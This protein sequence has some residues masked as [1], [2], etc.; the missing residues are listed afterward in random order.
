MAYE[1]ERDRDERKWFEEAGPPFTPFVVVGCV[2]SNEG[3]D[4]QQW[5]VLRTPA[6]LTSLPEI[7]QHIDMERQSSDPDRVTCKLP[8]SSC[9]FVRIGRSITNEFLTQK[10]YVGHTCR[11]GFVS[12]NTDPS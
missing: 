1:A 5:L 12:T 9:S 2:T 7:A 10:M 4:C 11:I 6:A 8:A 3:K